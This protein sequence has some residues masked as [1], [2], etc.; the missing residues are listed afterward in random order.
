[1]STAAGAVRVL[2]E[3]RATIAQRIAT[4]AALAERNLALRLRLSSLSLLERVL[5]E[6]SDHRRAHGAAP[7][8]LETLLSLL[9]RSGMGGNGDG[10]GDGSEPQQQPLSS[11]PSQPQ[12]GPGSSAYESGSCPND[13][14]SYSIGAGQSISAGQGSDGNTDA[15]DDSGGVFAQLPH[16]APGRRVLL[17]HEASEA[18]VAKVRVAD[19]AAIKRDLRDHHDAAVRLMREVEAAHA[20]SDAAALE[21]AQAELKEQSVR[22]SRYLSLVVRDALLDLRWGGGLGVV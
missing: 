14:G 17:L 8:P 15:A 1:M 16:L 9:L 5:A 22:F 21:C 18:E 7:G 11:A 12:S 2:R 4:L 6:I 20:A 13:S 3:A 19:A 10:D